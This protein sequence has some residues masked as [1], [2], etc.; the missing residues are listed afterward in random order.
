MYSNGISMR[1][2]IHVILN[3]LIFLYHTFLVKIS[4][5]LLNSSDAETSNFFGLYLESHF[6]MSVSDF[7]Q[8]NKL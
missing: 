3:W 5:F 4:A 7:V 6:I 8:Y 2:G 1:H